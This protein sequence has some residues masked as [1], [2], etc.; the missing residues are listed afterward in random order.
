MPDYVVQRIVAHLN[1]RE[2]AVKGRRILLAGLSY[3]KNTGDA[4]E[5]PSRRISELLVGLGAEVVAADPHVKPEHV[6]P[7]VTVVD[8]TEDEVS[9]AD[10]V[11]VLVDHDAFDLGMIASR[12][13]HVLDTRNCVQGPSVVTL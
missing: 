5:T 2:L 3:K 12:A 8:L 7:G 10:L 1:E 9:R 13:G 4:R 6:P 11:V